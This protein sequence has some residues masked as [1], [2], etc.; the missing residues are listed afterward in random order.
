VEYANRA[1]GA[2]GGTADPGPVEAAIGHY[3]RAL[4]LDP[5]SY[6]ARLR[7]LRAL[8]FRGGFCRVDAKD[9][10]RLFEE[11]KRVADE[12]VRLLEAQ[13]RESRLR[14][15]REAVRREPLAAEIYLW[16]AVS[17]GQWA[18]THRLGAVWQGAAG[19]IRDFAQAVV[20]IEPETL[21]GSAYLILG[22]LH[23]EAPRV[24]MLTPWVSRE[25]ALVCLRA[26]FRIAPQNSSNRYFLAEALNALRPDRRGEARLLLE[27]CAAAH[28]R[29]GFEVEDAHYAEQARD[30][31]ARSFGVRGATRE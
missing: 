2:R 16:A 22:R 1:L 19:Q 15:H 21:F 6:P 14:S 17:W 29:E 13:S 31:L 11:A 25:K 9:Q 18:T 30:L 23:A 12:T 7:L 26:A 3:R 24:P 4:A 27:R 28:P 5:S 10:I 20:D 8:F